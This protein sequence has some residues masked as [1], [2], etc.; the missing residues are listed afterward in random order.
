MVRAGP[1]GEQETIAIE[2]GVITI[3][4]GEIDDLTDLKTKEELGKSLST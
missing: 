3:G 2:K 4:W 1:H